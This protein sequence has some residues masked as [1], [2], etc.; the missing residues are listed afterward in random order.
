MLDFLKQ[1]A[2][3]L[4]V[5]FVFGLVMLAVGVKPTSMKFGVISTLAFFAGEFFF[6]YSYMDLIGLMD[7]LGTPGLDLSTP[8]PAIVWKFFGGT[9]FVIAVVCLFAWNGAIT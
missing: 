8:P 5:P 9:C 1:L 3:A 7:S 6:L 4:A 2:K